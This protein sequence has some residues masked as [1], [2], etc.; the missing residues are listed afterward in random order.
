[1]NPNL[2]K[3]ETDGED[4]ADACPTIGTLMVA[5]FSRPEPQLH[6]PA[7]YEADGLFFAMNP[8]R[9]MY[10][11]EAFKNEYDFSAND[12]QH[13]QRPTLWVLVVLMTPGHHLLLPVWRGRAFWRDL[14]TD[15]DVA[16]VLYRM[17]LREGLNL[18][19][20][21]SY[22]YDQRSRRS[23]AKHEVTKASRKPKKEVIH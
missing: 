15:Q 8:E 5:H 9:R 2:I 7:I 4:Y 18:G 6:A 12:E 1:M 17:C 22:I 23:N 20:W 3:H 16:N 10:V 13:A 14:Q 21:M 19:E 11:R